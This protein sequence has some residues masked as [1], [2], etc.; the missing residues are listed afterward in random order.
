[1][2]N[3]LFFDIGI[4]LIIA[5]AIAYLAK[6]IR[7]PLIPA[8][9]LTG[10]I[11]GPVLGLITNTE[12]I[13]ILSEI[14]IA[15]LLFIVGLEIDI[16]RLTNVA[17]ISSLGG[18]IRAVMLFT[19]GFVIALTLGFIPVEAI[20]IGLVLAFSSTMIV[21]KLLSDKRELDTLHA[22]IIVGILLMEDFLAIVALAMLSTPVL[23]ILSIF[24]ALVKV[25]FIILIAL[26]LSKFFFPYVFKYAAKVQELLFLA[27]ISVLFFFSVLSKYVGVILVF[28][29]ERFVDPS[30]IHMLEP[31][32]SIIIGAF[33]GGVVLANMPY[34]YEIIGRVTPLRDFFATIFFVSLG[35]GLLV[36]H[37][38]I[39]IVPL[40]IFLLFVFLLKPFVTMFLCSFFGYK[41]RPSFLT[42]LSLAQVSE[43]SLIIV[44]QGYIMGQVS[45]IIMSFTV[46]LTVITMIVTA[47]LIQFDEKIYNLL[48]KKLSIFEKIGNTSSNLEFMPKRIKT[49]VILVGYNRI[50]YSI[51]NKLKKLRKKSLVVDF[52]PEVIKELIKKKI[53]CLYGDI[54]DREILER[55]DFRDVEMVISTVPEKIDN[56]RLLK[57]VKEVNKKA[58]VVVTANHVEDALDLYDE[59]ADYV[60]L[61]H[62]LGGEHVSLLIEE[63][64][65]DLNRMIEKKLSHI[66]ELKKRKAM[67]HR[68][69]SH[70]D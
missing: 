46:L 17:L 60:V 44:T 26:V 10:V 61:P 62:F 50:G 49:K 32:L 69:P 53:P 59:G 11:L 6:L 3:I 35:M 70:H 30:I 51:Y 20:Y 54:G 45:G 22:R 41:K 33:V 9:I 65:A 31:G 67:G 15:F 23:S 58:L 7:Q 13:N 56:L 29:L 34:S 19:A 38:K 4:V 18:F 2:T 48:S 21:V 39:I 52:N 63:T 55:L 1:M 16:K 27:A 40:V 8:Y 64:S 24:M 28:C 43:F 47:Y 5:T 25:V 36:S 57:L 14:G 68:H 42:S 37:V 66:K 12:V